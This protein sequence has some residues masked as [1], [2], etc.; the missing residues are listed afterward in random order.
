MSLALFQTVRQ[1]LVFVFVLVALKRSHTSP[2]PKLGA[3]QMLN[4]VTQP[5]L[6][7]R[8]SAPKSRMLPPILNWL[9]KIF[10]AWSMRL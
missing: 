9:V 3:K 1:V 10:V 7:I 6:L 2:N 8:L 5:T 4:A